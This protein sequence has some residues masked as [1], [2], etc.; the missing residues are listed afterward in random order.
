M[1]GPDIATKGMAQPDFLHP[2]LIAVVRRKGHP[3][4]YSLLR[5]AR[6]SILTMGT[7]PCAKS[8]AADLSADAVSLHQARA[9][10]NQGLFGFSKTL[11][12]PRWQACQTL[13]HLERRPSPL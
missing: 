3:A 4:P 9:N 1:G 6:L 2:T 7:Q 10:R 11:A 8:E 5:A 12:K 13:A